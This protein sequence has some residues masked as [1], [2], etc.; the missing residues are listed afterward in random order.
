MEIVNEKYV[1][2]DY[3]ELNLNEEELDELCSL[4]IELIKED[5][6]SLVEYAVN[7]LMIEVVGSLHAETNSKEKV[8]LLKKYIKIRM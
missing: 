8:E 1:E 7:K 6:R 3:D 2:F 4:G 5:K